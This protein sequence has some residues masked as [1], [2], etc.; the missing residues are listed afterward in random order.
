MC[1]EGES[2]L[3]DW[4]RL[5]TCLSLPPP[6]PGENAMPAGDN[7]NRESFQ[8]ERERRSEGGGRGRAEERGQA[9]EQFE[10]QH[11]PLV[12]DD[13]SPPGG[14]P[15]TYPPRTMLSTNSVSILAVVKAGLVPPSS[16][17]H[18]A[19]ESSPLGQTRWLERKDTRGG[20]GL[21]ARLII[22]ASSHVATMRDDPA[23]CAG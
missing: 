10:W 22:H 6:P 18:S 14:V 4:G 2:V 8:G 9:S 3:R 16:S 5:T 23:Q 1:F 21:G 20:G 11:S 15:P 19:T 12:G 13:C 7:E 17:H